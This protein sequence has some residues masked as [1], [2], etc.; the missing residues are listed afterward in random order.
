M[1]ISAA[2]EAEILDFLATHPRW[3]LRDGRLCVSLRFADFRSAFA[4]MTAI[5]LYA[6][7]HDHHPEWFNA[8]N[9]LDIALI[10]HE[11]GAISA[12]D[13]A[14]AQFIDALVPADGH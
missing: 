1:S 12:R 6:E 7:R 10:T 11:A 8:Y 14:L 13:L 4:G 2:A 9:R 3:S 5:A